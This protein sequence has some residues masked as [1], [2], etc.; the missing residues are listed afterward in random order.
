MIADALHFACPVENEVHENSHRCDFRREIFLNFC[1][2]HVSKKGLRMLFKTGRVVCQG[3]AHNF[4]L[5]FRV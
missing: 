5:A 1:L 2:L 4:F 3:L